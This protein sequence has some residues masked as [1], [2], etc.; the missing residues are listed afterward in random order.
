GLGLRRLAGGGAQLAQA[1]LLRRQL[2]TERGDV[3]LGVGQRD[4]DAL[5]HR[6]G[7]RGAGVAAVLVRGTFGG[8][9]GLEL[10]DG[11]A[12]ADDVRVRLGVLAQ[13]LVELLLLRVD[14][15]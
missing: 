6:A 10:A 2:R 4:A 12:R 3:G 1:R 14:A 5:E 9:L 8:A 11:L 13:Q 7:G 15:R